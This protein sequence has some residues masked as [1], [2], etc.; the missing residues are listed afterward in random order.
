MTGTLYLIP[1]SLGDSP[2][3][4]YC[5]ET[6]KVVVERLNHF[7]VENARTAR[8]SI[9]SLCPAKDLSVVQLYEV[10]K[11]R[12]YSYPREEVLALLRSGVDV[13]FMSEAGCPCVADPGAIVVADCHRAGI[14]VV[15]LVGPS[16]ILLSLMASGF[17]G[18]SF[19]FHG[20]LPFDD[21]V[22]RRLLSD[23]AARVRKSGETQIFIE[24]PYRNDRLLSD[25]VALL[26]GD[27]SLCM[28][29]DLTTEQEEIHRMTIREWSKLLSESKPTW[30]KRPAIFLLGK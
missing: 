12:G 3:A 2:T 7:V 5:P 22:R 25:L 28:A 11:H 6:N 4:D 19:C 18:Q 13:G 9:R 29:V 21:K 30:H 14:R 8:R 16:S 23:F 26:P 1:V 24:A 15:P 20:Y 17:S 27:L 10:D